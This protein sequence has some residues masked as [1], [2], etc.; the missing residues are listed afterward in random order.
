MQAFRGDPVVVDD[1]PILLVAT[2]EYCHTHR[3]GLFSDLNSDQ[4]DVL[5]RCRQRAI[6]LP[7]KTRDRTKILLREPWVTR[8]H[9]PSL[10]ILL[11]YGRT[12]RT[13][14]QVTNIF[15]GTFQSEDVTC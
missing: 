3:I 10:S 5:D 9:T 7:S 15:N 12:G 2:R 8:R 13:V 1:K 11:A 14:S 4:D 6:Y